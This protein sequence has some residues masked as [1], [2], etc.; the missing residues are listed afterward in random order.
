MPGAHRGAALIPSCTAVTA[1]RKLAFQP[2]FSFRVE[3]L[4]LL[5][6]THSP[7]Q[8]VHAKRQSGVPHL[9]SILFTSYHLT[10]FCG[11]A[12]T[13][14]QKNAPSSL[15]L[16]VIVELKLFAK[17]SSYCTNLEAHEP[18]EPDETAN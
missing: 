5:P 8:R 1:V 3:I 2:Q 12:F 10:T 15:S 11:S 14:S 4:W 17:T 7:E 6:H 13:L 9:L 18:D 16:L